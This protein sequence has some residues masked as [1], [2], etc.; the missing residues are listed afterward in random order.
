MKAAR[1]LSLTLK[2]R[3]DLREIIDYTEQKWGENQAEKYF[4]Q[5]MEKCRDLAAGVVSGRKRPEL[6]GA[7]FSYPAGS[8]IIFYQETKNAIR[9]LRILHG[10]RDLPLHF[11]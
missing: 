11:D 1:K 2:A 10:A 4:N 6:K 3:M 9:V 5:I 8:H 7:P